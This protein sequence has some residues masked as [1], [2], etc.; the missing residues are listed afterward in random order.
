MTFSIV[1]RDTSSGKFG[2]AISTRNLAVGALCCH[3]Q[4]GIGAIATQASTNPLLGINGL[5]LLAEGLDAQ[6]TLNRLSEGDEGRAHRQLHIVDQTGKTAAWTGDQCVDWAGNRAL[7]GFSVAGNMLTGADV[8]AAM[9]AAYAAQPETVPLA[10]RLLSAL[11]AGQAAGGDKRGRQSAALLIVSTEL[12]PDL[13][14]R[15]DDHVDPVAELHRI[16][17]ESQKD[18]YQTFRKNMPTQANPFGNHNS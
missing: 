7:S 18:Y 17:Q 1:A 9:A 11:A 10:E 13:D 12:Y 5:R 8:I 3:A 2:V 4:A 6:A 14:L 15:V 16:Y